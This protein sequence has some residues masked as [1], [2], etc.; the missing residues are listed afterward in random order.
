MG[1]RGPWIWEFVKKFRVGHDI[2]SYRV[3][4]IAISCALVAFGTWTG[5]APEKGGGKVREKVHEQVREK[6][7]KKMKEK[8]RGKCGK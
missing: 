8:C 4:V 2:E 7:N 6:A 3:G 1:L 5:A